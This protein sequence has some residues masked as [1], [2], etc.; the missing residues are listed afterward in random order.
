M[1]LDLIWRRCFP[2]K[3]SSRGRLSGNES[4]VAEFDS[5]W[6]TTAAN[7]TVFSSGNPQLPKFLS[8]KLG[9]D[10][11]IALYVSSSARNFVLFSSV[12]V[13][14]LLVFLFVC[15]CCFWGVVL[16]CLFVLFCFSALSI[17]S[18][19]FSLI[20]FKYKM[21]CHNSGNETFTCDLINFK[22]LVLARPSILTGS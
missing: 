14:V 20:R 1:C 19:S 15:C 2:D 22:C 21:T 12:F 3:D 9:V 5:R 6:S 4:S 18:T 8:C 13:C 10:Q 11:N 17:H 7:I 16:F